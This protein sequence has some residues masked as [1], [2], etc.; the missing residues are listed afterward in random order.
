MNLHRA[1]QS[2][3]LLRQTMALECEEH[4]DDE[5]STDS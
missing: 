3:T 4:G 2:A 1:A 5:S